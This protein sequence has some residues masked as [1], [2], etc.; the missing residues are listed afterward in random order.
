[1]KPYFSIIIPTYNRG[2]CIGRMIESILSQ[3]FKEFELII[4]D[5]GSTDDT[6]AVVSHFKD[7]RI[8]FK[9][10]DKNAGANTARN[11][12]ARMARGE[13]IISN[14]SDDLFTSDALKIAYDLTRKV[15]SDL[16]FAACVDLDGRVTSNNPEFEG[17][18]EF[19]D[20]LRGRVVVG[21]YVPI[22]KRE[23]FASVNFYYED[24]MGGE[25]TTWAGIIK[26]TGRVFFSKSIVRIYNNKGSDR[27][28]V[29]SKN[30]KRLA[31]VFKKDLSVLWRDYLFYAPQKFFEKAAKYVIYKML[32]TV[33]T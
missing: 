19:K 5:D 3:E 15:D 7:D 30:F 32:S 17:F 28:S 6:V 23:V 27:L 12:G 8:F 4:I 29:K 24:V 2:Y 11:I 16:I 22:V 10:L 33:Q 26:K 31:V 18:L 13:W 20:Y 1:M 21:E 9:A 25:G 14:D